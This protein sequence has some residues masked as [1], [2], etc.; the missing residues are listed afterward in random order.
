MFEP[1][2]AYIER[3]KFDAKRE[4]VRIYNA[5]SFYYKDNRWHKELP[6][7][8][9]PRYYEFEAEANFGEYKYRF[10]D[11]LDANEYL[12]NFERRGYW[13][14]IKYQDVKSKPHYGKNS[15]LW[16]DMEPG[17][18]I[19]QDWAVDGIKET[20]ALTKR[21]K[22][23]ELIYT[24]KRGPDVAWRDGVLTTPE[25]VLAYIPPPII[26]G[27]QGELLGV[28]QLTF[29][30]VGKLDNLTLILPGIKDLIKQYGTVYV[31]PS[32]YQVVAGT[33]GVWQ[34]EDTAY[35]PVTTDYKQA[36]VAYVGQSLSSDGT[37]K[38]N[39][40]YFSFNTDGLTGS[41]HQVLWKIWF[42]AFTGS[43][44]YMVGVYEG[45]N[46]WAGT[47]WLWDAGTFEGTGTG[48]YADG[49]P[50]ATTVGNI[51]DSEY[52]TKTG[53]WIY[54][55]LK[56]DAL[57]SS[58]STQFMLRTDRDV[59]SITPSTGNEYCTWGITS[60]TCFLEVIK[61]I[62][63]W[64]DTPTSRT[65]IVTD[66]NTLP[67][68]NSLAGSCANIDIGYNLVNWFDVPSS[69]DF[70]YYNVSLGSWIGG[71]IPQGPASDGTGSL[72]AS[73]GGATHTFELDTY[74]G[75][76]TAFL[77][78][79]R[80]RLRSYNGT[81]LVG[82][83]SD[84]AYTGWFDVDNLPEAVTLEFPANTFF[85]GWGT[86]EFRATMSN[87]RGG[88]YVHFRFRMSQSS[89]FDP[90]EFWRDTSEGTSYWYHEVAAGSWTEM[91]TPGVY[92][93]AIAGGNMVKYIMQTSEKPRTGTY[94]W[95][96][97]E[98]E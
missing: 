13:F 86:Y 16:A 23:E 30:S 35:P 83:V 20:I 2:S 1:V 76:G 62:S 92:A 22:R 82:S 4:I 39:H 59:G 37:Y 60:G 56:D 89:G 51:L 61:S 34:R 97:T 27:P 19:R 11:K 75:L 45:V 91:P 65:M 31:D 95:D 18:E 32:I 71:A 57:T 8:V 80:G 25:G 55:R 28:G 24:I 69:I 78:S 21:F 41:I 49:N 48:Y 87:L 58:G 6:E 84:W 98:G 96:I 53:A 72:A 74:T 90:I 93:T 54:Y 26:S 38:Q 85:G 40:S 44:N 9:D 47:N 66:Y 33:S 94:Y 43:K 12:V 50:A 88:S 3:D 77:G 15:V 70:E 79:C 5:P 81:H 67:Q 73:S 68:I 36:N 42:N 46:L 17:V 63:A 10:G 7:L 64:G 52:G 14:N 29:E